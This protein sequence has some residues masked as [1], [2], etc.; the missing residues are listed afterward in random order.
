[1]K[2]QWLLFVLLL[3]NA[4]NNAQTLKYQIKAFGIKAGTLEIKRTTNNGLEQFE[5]E[6]LNEVNYLV[7]KIKVHH[8]TRSTFKNGVLQSSYVRNEKNDKVEYYSSVSYDGSNYTIVNEKEK[9]THSGAVSYT[10]CHLFNTE[11]VSYTEVFS[12]RLGIYLPIKKKE[13][14]VYE[15]KYPDG[16]KYVYHYENG[17]MIKADISTKQGKAHMYL[18]N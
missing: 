1:M 7:G 10:I 9:L 2:K 11:P 6:S 14:H 8:I 5:I 13:E 16:D 12:E 4:E 17:K 3:I 18:M 15:F